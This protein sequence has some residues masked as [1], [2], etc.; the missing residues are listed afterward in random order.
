MDAAE[1]GARRLTTAM[2]VVLVAFLVL[3]V[4]AHLGSGP[5]GP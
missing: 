4:L 3:A 2:R 5:V 1:D